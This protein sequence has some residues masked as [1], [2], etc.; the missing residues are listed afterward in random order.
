M[1][2]NMLVCNALRDLTAILYNA[3]R[4]C[5]CSY[6]AWTCSR[7]ITHMI[8]KIYNNV[9]CNIVYLQLDIERR[10]Q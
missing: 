7:M 6:Y 2:P 8:T 4:G 10:I 3:I 5:V 1:F 9:S